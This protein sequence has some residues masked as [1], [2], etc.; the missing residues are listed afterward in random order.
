MRPRG[1]RRHR[2]R[3]R[4]CHRSERPTRTTYADASSIGARR[5]DRVMQNFEYA[6]PTTL[7]DALALLG[8]KWGETDVLAGGTDGISL[9]K[10][11]LHTPNRRVNIKGIKE[12]GGISRK[13]QGLGIRATVTFDQ[14]DS[15]QSIPSE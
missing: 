8:S 10:D 15:H 7:H 5:E 4:K 14:H 6:N 13:G 3:R 1:R 9:L 11:F 12:R 2:Q